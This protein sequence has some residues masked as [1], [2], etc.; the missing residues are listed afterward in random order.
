[1]T[2]F[3]PRTSGIRSD[4][5]TNCGTTTAPVGPGYK[6]ITAVNK[7]DFK[8]GALVEGLWDETRNMKV[9]CSNPSTVSLYGCLFEKDRK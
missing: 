6:S 2:G 7:D 9:V 3:K 5:S 4:R 8:A 1:M